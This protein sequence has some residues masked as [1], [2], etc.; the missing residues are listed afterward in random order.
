[1][2][3]NEFKTSLQIIVL[4]FVIVKSQQFFSI[5]CRQ[6]NK[7]MIA[8]GH[9]H[10]IENCIDDDDGFSEHRKTC[11]KTNSSK[12]HP[13]DIENFFLSVEQSQ[14]RNYLNRKFENRCV[15]ILDDKCL[16]IMEIYSFTTTTIRKILWVWSHSYSSKTSFVLHDTRQF[17]NTSFLAMLWVSS[18][19]QTS[20]KHVLDNNHGHYWRFP[21]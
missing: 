10:H 1:M 7:Q 13:A 14:Q 21:V 8:Y 12:K 19:F 16:Y 3:R 2:L 6:F 17:K 5:F 4:C 15:R 18:V 9:T 20:G 11:A